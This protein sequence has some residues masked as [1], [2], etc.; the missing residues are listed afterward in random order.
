[1]ETKGQNEMK[2]LFIVEN[3]RR[4]LLIWTKK[5]SQKK[6]EQFSFFKI[7]IFQANMKVLYTLKEL[8]KQI[9]KSIF[10]MKFS[11]L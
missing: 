6:E 3:S 4:L 8:N 5:I 1:M 11:I 7:F 2:D 10:S 9:C